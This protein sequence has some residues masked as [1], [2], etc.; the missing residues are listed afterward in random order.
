MRVFSCFLLSG[1][2]ALALFLTGCGGGGSSSDHNLQ[3]GTVLTVTA[4]TELQ[5]LAATRGSSTMQVGATIEVIDFK[6]GTTI[7]TGTIGS[8]GSGQVS[9]SAGLTVAVLVKG[10]LGTKE[11]R[12]ST[13]I[14]VVPSTATTV[15]IDPVTSIA[16]EVLAQKHFGS[17][18][19]QTTF[20]NAKGAAL[21][22]FLANPDADVALGNGLINN[23]SQF[24]GNNAIN[25]ETLAP[26]EDTV[27]DEIDD[28]LVKAKNAIQQIKE[29]PIPFTAVL[30]QERPSLERM[31]Q[32]MTSGGVD[33]A[34]FGAINDKYRILSDRL[35]ALLFPAIGGDWHYVGMRDAN[36]FQLTMGEGYR[37]VRHVDNNYGFPEE[38]LQIS[39]D[40]SLRVADQVTVVYTPDALGMLRGGAFYKII[41]TENATSWNVVQTYSGDAKLRYAAIVPKVGTLGGNPEFTGHIK[42]EDQYLTEP[43]IF[44]GTAKATGTDKDHYTHMEYN[45]KLTSEELVANGEFAVDFP[46]TL[47][48]GAD[49]FQKTYD[50]P[51]NFSMRNAYINVTLPNMTASIAGEIAVN[52][53]TVMDGDELAC[54]PSRV[55]LSGAKFAASVGQRS[56]EL[57]GNIDIGMAYIAEGD[58]Y[59]SYPTAISASNGVKVS[60][61]T[62]DIT[63]SGSFAGTSEM[64][65]VGGEATVYPSYIKLTGAYNNT[66]SKQSFNGSITANWDNPGVATD[67]LTAEGSIELVGELK[68]Q[69]YAVYAADLTFKNDGAGNVTCDIDKIAWLANQLTGSATGTLTKTGVTAA[70]LTLDNQDGVHFSMALTAGAVTG[71]ISVNNVQQATIIP[72]NGL[73]KIVF[74]DNTHEYLPK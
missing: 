49:P 3:P 4:S 63:V 18:F 16:S 35:N 66:D 52:C 11:Y 26:V 31:Y 29:A 7:A 37:V 6:T 48:M 61:G 32:S 8:N 57:T 68:S 51:T 30:Q 25:E 62:N 2:L 23:N 67:L 27:P 14:P 53:T 39:V 17:T 43:I 73:L 56:V 38:W 72:E 47:P 65:M 28:S 24:A 41:V 12:L 22:Y 60:N 34:P 64:L 45:G 42:L 55:T 54:V 69:G 19:D 74:T 1:I 59:E 50:F 44:D 33:T 13:L 36:L 71:T 40:S 21:N 9:V 20:E 70:A 15:V 5:G 10:K 46:D 58:S